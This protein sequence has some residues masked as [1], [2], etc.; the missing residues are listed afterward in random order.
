MH[1]AIECKLDA[2]HPS[3]TL[4]YAVLSPKISHPLI[5]PVHAFFASV[6]SRKKEKQTIFP[7][8]HID[9]K[10]QAKSQTKRKLMASNF[11][12]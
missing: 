12:S 11:R 8:N 3:G 10:T 4:G 7:Y 1:M 6:L 9:I 5:H 2:S